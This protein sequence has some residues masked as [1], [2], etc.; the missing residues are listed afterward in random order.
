MIKSKDNAILVALVNKETIGFIVLKKEFGG[1]VFVEWLA[2]TSEFRGKGIGTQLLK[3][4]ESWA[5]QQK[6]HYAYLYTETQKN[7]GYYT[8]RGFNLVGTHTNAW[9]GETENMMGKHLAD[10]PFEEIF[11]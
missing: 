6:C 5:L 1:V 9:F 3:H 11:D 7:I 8:A 4:M 10:K 2:V